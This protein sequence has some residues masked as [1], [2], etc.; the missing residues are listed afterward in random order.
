MENEL[1]TI[2]LGLS[3]DDTARV[4]TARLRHLH[5]AGRA[6]AN[7]GG[8]NAP[9]EERILCAPDSGNAPLSAQ[10]LREIHATA[11]SALIEAAAMGLGDLEAFRF[12]TR[13]ARRMLY[14]R[15]KTPVFHDDAKARAGGARAHR[16]FIT[17]LEE[18]AEA[19]G[20]SLEPETFDPFSARDEGNARG[21]YARTLRCLRAHFQTQNYP[22]AQKHEKQARALLRQLAEELQAG[23]RP[24]SFD[25]KDNEAEAFRARVQSL[26]SQI[27]KGRAILRAREAAVSLSFADRRAEA[28]AADRK[29]ALVKQTETFQTE[30]RFN[31]AEGRFSPFALR[32]IKQAEAREKRARKRTLKSLCDL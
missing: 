30:T 24:W 7:K 28:R 2:D 10:D 29:R 8:R 22:L 27:E 16:L 26:L 3:F 31:A 9:P 20:R 23:L 25:R 14:Q 11:V 15:L 13:A 6:Y 17:Q 19:E 12:A 18:E 1:E 21:R 4:I 32:L 5:E